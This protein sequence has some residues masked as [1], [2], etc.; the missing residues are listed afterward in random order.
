MEH[1]ESAAGPTSAPH[2][3]DESQGMRRRNLLGYAASAPLLSAVAGLGGLAAPSSANAAILPMTPPDTTDQLDIG[4]AVTVTALPTMPLVKVSNIGNGRVR[5]ELPRFESGQGIATA[6]AMMLADKLGL[7]LSAIEVGSADASP[8]LFY[9]QLTGGSSS[10]RSLHAGMPL[11]GGLGGQPSGS[12]SAVVGQ[13]VTR[14]DA[15]DIVTGRKKFTLDQAVP[16]AKPTMVCRPPTINGQF[17]RINNTT[18]VMG[19]PGVLGIAPI[20]ATNGIVPTP[21]GVAVMAETF[22]QAGPR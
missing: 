19:M 18:A 16:D 15:L 5:L 6:A 14:L 2:H 12:G 7:P 20:P 17:V 22:G 21:P 1:P 13:R 10:V 11:L 4:D 8:E 3:D 9:N